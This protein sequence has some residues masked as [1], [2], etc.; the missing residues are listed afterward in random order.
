[1]KKNTSIKDILDAASQSKEH[2]A[3]LRNDF[4][5]RMGTFKNH[6]S[7]AKQQ[8]LAE[9]FGQV[10]HAWG[11][12]NVECIHLVVRELRLRILI[13]ALPAVLCAVLAVLMPWPA[14]WLPLVLVSPPC[15]LGAVITLWR[16][17]VLTRQQYQPFMCWLCS[18][19][20]FA[21]KGA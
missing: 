2:L 19:V 5:S 1:M 10:L 17:S 14:A 21:K 11:I 12:D 7:A 16:V 15:L 3:E 9:D 8:E 13:F 20:G 18:F 4:S 6:R